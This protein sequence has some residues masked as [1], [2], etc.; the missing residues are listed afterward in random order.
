MEELMPGSGRWTEVFSTRGDLSKNV[1]SPF[2][3]QVRLLGSIWNN[4]SGVQRKKGFYDEG[5]LIGEIQNERIAGY[6]E[7]FDSVLLVS[8]LSLTQ[9]EKRIFGAI[10]DK[11]TVI[12]QDTKSYDFSRIISFREDLSHGRKEKKGSF[13]FLHA[14]SKMA[15]VMAVLALI[16]DELA[17]GVRPNEIAV[18]NND[19]DTAQMLYDS[20]RSAGID[21][22]FSEG[23]KIKK[24]PL[25]Q[26]LKLVFRFFGSGFDAE[27]FVQLLRNEIFAELTL[28]SREESLCIEREIQHARMFSLPS[29][30]IPPVENDWRRKDLFKL[31]GELYHSNSIKILYGNL[32]RL[33]A[34]FGGKKTYEFYTVRDVLLDSVLELGDLSV[35]FQ[36]SPF[37]IFLQY[38]EPKRYPLPGIYRR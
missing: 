11:L 32:E 21:T 34:L 22:N 9:F 5:V 16:E 37:E 1:D 35:K 38:V 27:L 29:L 19:S 24:S 33:F 17:A 13:H 14:P 26:F 23:M 36:E 6:F 2:S 25:Y 10:E 7:S 15:Q 12:Y 18:I 4:Y 8:P 3:I 20:M 30:D 31:L 28:T